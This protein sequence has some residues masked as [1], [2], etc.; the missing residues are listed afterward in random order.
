VSVEKPLLFRPV[1]DRHGVVVDVE[2]LGGWRDE[3]DIAPSLLDA[4]NPPFLAHG[5][6]LVVFRCKSSVA[7][8]GIVGER[9]VVGSPYPTMLRARL[10]QIRPTS[11]E[12]EDPCT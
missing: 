8:Y 2:L 10:L 12:E 6:G 4:G 3:I 9:A 5:D 11:A 1:R 7:T